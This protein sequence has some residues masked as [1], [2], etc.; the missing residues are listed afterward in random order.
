M[1][2]PPEA[3][4]AA[5]PPTTGSVTVVV[6]ASIVMFVAG[7]VPRIDGKPRVVADQ[8]H[9]DLVAGGE[10]VVLREQR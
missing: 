6:L 10:D 8:D 4:A 2:K 9:A 5:A 1:S 3:A 7:P